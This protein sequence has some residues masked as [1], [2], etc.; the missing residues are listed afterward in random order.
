MPF[1]AI[2]FSLQYEWESIVF[3]E[4]IESR[5]LPRFLDVRVGEVIKLGLLRLCL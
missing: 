2:A 5:G 3:W 4:E 1:L